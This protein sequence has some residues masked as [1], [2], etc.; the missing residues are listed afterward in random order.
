MCGSGDRHRGSLALAH[1]VRSLLFGV[2]PT[3]AVPFAGASIGLL[4]VAAIASVVPAR[5]AASIDRLRR[6]AP[7][8]AAGL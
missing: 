5:P 6:F 8:D 7:N 4:V 1:A 2:G 3:D